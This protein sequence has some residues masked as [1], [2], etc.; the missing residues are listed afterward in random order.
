MKLDS[1]KQRIQRS[2]YRVDPHAVAAALLRRVGDSRTIFGLPPVS[3]DD[4]RSRA[5]IAAPFD[6]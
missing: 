6:R 1:L 4:A 3:R 5:A 2:E